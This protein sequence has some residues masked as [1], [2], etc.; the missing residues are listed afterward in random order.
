MVA[1]TQQESEAPAADEA[2]PQAADETATEAMI[3]DALSAA[4]P[5]LAAVA[6]VA[7]WE[8][9]VLRQGSG[10][11]TCLPTPAQMPAGTSPMC[12]DEAWM[13]WADAWA[14]KSEFTPD[15]IG[16]S[17]MLGGD[18][19]ASNVDPYATGETEDNEWVVEGPHL[20]IIVPDNAM[21]AGLPTD[22]DSGGPYVM[23]RD[24][25]YAHVMVPV[26]D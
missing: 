25:P 6:S 21:L 9:N 10:G 5:S 18:G 22:P 12:M 2:A 14:N 1:C 11:Y 16:I 17:Y 19:G 7:D 15:G 13:G 24:T 8:G 20:M 3:A 26:A 23:W 4:P